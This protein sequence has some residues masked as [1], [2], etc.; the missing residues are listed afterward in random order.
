MK[1]PFC[2]QIK[3]KYHQRKNQPLF[4]A[5]SK[6]HHIITFPRTNKNEKTDKSEKQILLLNQTRK[7]GINPLRA[8]RRRTKKNHSDIY[9]TRQGS[10]NE[11]F[12]QNKKNLIE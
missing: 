8:E 10:L 11:I 7:N 3:Y 6:F 2:K 5:F 9:N 12:V 4:V 1:I